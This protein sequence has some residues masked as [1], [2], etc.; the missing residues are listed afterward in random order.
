ML[1]VVRPDGRSIIWV[2]SQTAEPRGEWRSPDQNTILAVQPVGAKSRILTIEFH[3]D[4]TTPG[5]SSGRVFPFGPLRPTDE[6]LIC[7]HDLDKPESKPLILER[8]KPA[9]ERGRFIWPVLSI[10]P[11][12]GWVAVSHLFEEQIRILEPRMV[13]NLE[14][15]PHRCRFR[16]LPQ[17]PSVFWLSQEGDRS[18]FGV[19]KSSRRSRKVAGRQW[20]YPHLELSLE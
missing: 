9:A 10:S 14:V 2:D 16:R 15:S 18:G 5:S 19:T 4:L 17:V 13:V 7:I 3:P 12:G 11:D 6:F 8:I 20:H 1:G